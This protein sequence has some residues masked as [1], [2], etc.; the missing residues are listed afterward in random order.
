MDKNSSIK[1]LPSTLNGTVKAPPSKSLAH[2]ALIASA[3]SN[4]KSIISNV[5]FSKDIIATISALE[6]IGAKFDIKG[7]KITVTGVKKIKP[8]HKEVY[9][10]ESG[11]TLRFLIPIFS[12]SQKKVIFSG[13]RSLIKRPQK[14]YEKIFH[15]DSNTFKVNETSIEI[16]G[17]IKARKYYLDGNVSSQF[18]SGLMFSLPLLKKDSYIYLNT[19]LESK[20]YIDLTIEVLEKFGIKILEIENGYYI[21]GN[22]SYKSTDYEIPGDFSQAAFF[23]V[24]GLINDR[25]IVEDLDNDSIQG[26]RR[27]IDVIK[28]VKGHIVHME[29]GFITNKSNTYG[30]VVDISDCPDLGPI[31]ALLL[32]LSFGYSRIVNASRLR[33]KESDRIESTVNSLKMLGADIESK[34][35]EIIIHG[36]KSL[37]GGVTLDSYNDHRIAMMISI[38]SSVCEKAVTLSNP[39]AINKSYPNFYKDYKSIGGLIE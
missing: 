21:E 11:S 24:A 39:S 19:K 22:Q 23:L 10:D 37:G 2:R 6:T 1:L 16:E 18:F 25:I 27:I 3:L 32:S 9:C 33:I 38:A 14:I 34:G 5:D 13:E 28:Q 29:N 12:L 36:R 35:D 15:D 26:D 30:T 7:T 31:I 4:G 8:P 17:S 20:S